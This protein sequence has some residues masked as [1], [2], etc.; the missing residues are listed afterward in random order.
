MMMKE[1]LSRVR[2]ELLRYMPPTAT[3]PL[4]PLSVI[5]LSVL[6]T[7]PFPIHLPRSYP[8]GITTCPSFLPPQ[9]CTRPKE[10]GDDSSPVLNFLS[11]Q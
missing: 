4:F 5:L 2:D 3:Y 10:H 1:I 8:Y 11:H 7:T 9:H 6:I